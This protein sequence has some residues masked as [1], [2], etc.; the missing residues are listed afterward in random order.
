MVATDVRQ[1]GGLAVPQP[2]TSKGRELSLAPDA[3]GELRR[4]DDVRG[5]ADALRER[6]AEDGYLLLPQLLDRELVL[7]AR[8]VMC[9]QLADLGLLDPRYP[10][11]EAVVSPEPG[12]A[13]RLPGIMDRNTLVKANAPLWELLYAGRMIAFYEQVFRGPVTHFDYTWTRIVKP[14]GATP[15]HYDIVFM[16]R[17]THNLV[18]AWTPL[19]DIDVPLGG[20]MLLEGSHKIGELRDGYGQSDVDTVCA[21]RFD[22]AWLAPDGTRNRPADATGMLSDDHVMLQQRYGGRWLT[23]EYRAGDLLTFGMYTLHASIDNRTNRWRLSTD[24]RYQRAA[25]PA[26]HRWMGEEPIGHGP[27]SARGVIC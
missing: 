20:L 27:N 17:G 13:D 18:T 14:G 1:I 5:D 11:E 23:A 6:L 2:L 10:V 15:A 26:D 12:A 4:S 19:G 8:R 24:S 22:G 7:A 16:S 21:N 3:F 9:R 25:E